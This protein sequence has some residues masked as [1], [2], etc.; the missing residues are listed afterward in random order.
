MPQAMPM[1]RGQYLLIPER[2]GTRASRTPYTPITVIIGNIKGFMPGSLG[3]Q[4]KNFNHFRISDAVCADGT[5]ANL[6]SIDFIKV[7]TGV[8]ATAGHLGEVSTE[9]C[10]IYDYS[11]SLL[12]KRTKN[13]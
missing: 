13:N 7:Q 5:P 3:E 11:R 10:G 2:A 6:P 9:V 8:N 1:T 4:Q 12:Q